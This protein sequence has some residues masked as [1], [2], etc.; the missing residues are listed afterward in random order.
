[1][2]GCRK[3]EEGKIDEAE[4]EKHR[5]EKL[6][7]EARKARETKGVEYKPRWFR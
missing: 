2:S 6:Q 3:L 1:M 7:R 5:V 4:T